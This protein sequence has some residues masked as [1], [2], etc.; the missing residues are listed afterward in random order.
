MKIYKVTKIIPSKYGP[1]EADTQWFTF[2]PSDLDSTYRVTS[3][4]FLSDITYSTLLEKAYGTDLTLTNAE[5]AAEIATKI[6]DNLQA[7]ELKVPNKYEG[8]LNKA[9]IVGFLEACKYQQRQV[10]E[11]T[12]KVTL[13]EVRLHFKKE[14]ED[15]HS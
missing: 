11:L 13:L 10:A 12:A 3:G 6:V 9:A 2:E 7:E 4:H 1:V 14:S 8:Q 15:A 5:K